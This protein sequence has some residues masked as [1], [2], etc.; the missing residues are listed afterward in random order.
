MGYTH[1]TLVFS[2][3]APEAAVVT[4]QSGNGEE[5]SGAQGVGTEK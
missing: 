5:A 1:L 4:R 2:M 3:L